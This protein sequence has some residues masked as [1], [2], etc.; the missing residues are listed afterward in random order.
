VQI[1]IVG[2]LVQALQVSGVRFQVSG[3]S[4]ATGRRSLPLRGG[5]FNR[6]RNFVGLHRLFLD[7]GSGF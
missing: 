7:C 2:D 5:Q 4:A 3:V 6:K 1:K